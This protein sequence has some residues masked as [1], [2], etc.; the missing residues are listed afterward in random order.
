MKKN[1]VSTIGLLF[2][3]IHATLAHVDAQQP[4]PAPLR[5]SSNRSG[6]NLPVGAVICPLCN[7]KGHF[8]QLTVYARTTTRPDGSQLTQRWFGFDPDV[9]N[10]LDNSGSS[11]FLFNSA[12]CNVV[13]WIPGASQAAGT[14]QNGWVGAP[15]AAGPDVRNTGRRFSIPA[16]IRR[17]VVPLGTQ[18]GC[19]SCGQGRHAVNGWIPDHMPPVALSTLNATSFDV[20]GPTIDYYYRPHNSVCAS[21]QG[22]LVSGL[23]TV[24]GGPGSKTASWKT[25]WENSDPRF[26]TYTDRGY[27]NDVHR[28]AFLKAK[29]D[30]IAQGYT[31]VTF[32]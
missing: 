18:F 10:D 14:T 27:P 30:L 32:Q 24:A 26:D 15:R 19:H 3:C 29:A 25:K 1:Q 2:L 13:G 23:S 8:G 12:S 17:D 9:P 11:Q 4:T 16:W 22:G 7:G 28:Q 5:R 31:E 20:N 6:S 21:R